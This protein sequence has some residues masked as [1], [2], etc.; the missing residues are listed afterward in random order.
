M[1]WDW[2][3]GTATYDERQKAYLGRIEADLRDH[4]EVAKPKRYAHSLSVART[5]EQMALAYGV[6]AFE[7]RAAG[8]LHD[9]DKVLSP[10][11][12]IAYARRLGV[13]LGVDSQ[14]VQPLLH[15]I[16]AARSLPERYPELPATVWQAIE[17]HTIGAADMSELDMVVFVADGIEPIRK[18]VPAIHNVRQLVE[19][20]AP[21]SEVFWASFSSGVSYVID[22]ERYLYPGTLDI[23]N[24]LVLARL[25]KK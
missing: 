1:A 13:D 16:T 23:Y 2:S 11:E 10:E 5:A 4:M 25:R 22:T 6:D 14:L 18:D 24:E 21:L 17:R 3:Y 19:R 15:G 12:Q 20:G 8:I 7:A 9:W